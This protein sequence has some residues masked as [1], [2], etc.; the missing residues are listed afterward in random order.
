MNERATVVVNTIERVS[1][2]AADDVLRHTG[3]CLRPQVHLVVNSRPNP[4]LGHV[5]TRPYREGRDA[6][7]AIARLGAPA[8][9]VRATQVVLIWE[10]QDLW[11]SLLGPGGYPTGMAVVIATTTGHVLHWHPAVFHLVSHGRRKAPT[12]WPQWGP[13]E[14]VDN[15]ELPHVITDALDRWR[16]FA[17]DGPH[18]FEELAADGYRV[19]LTEQT[20]C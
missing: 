13:V 17:D 7:A 4:Y 18:M 15:A 16:A 3:D 12:I 9:A 14:T 8:A 19:S 5:A 11:V 20:R 6:A 10:E 1:L 2:A